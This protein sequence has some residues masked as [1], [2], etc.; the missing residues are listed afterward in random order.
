MT[1]ILTKTPELNALHQVIHCSS[2]NCPFLLF[3]ADAKAFFSKSSQW[4][5]NLIELINCIIIFL[6]HLRCSLKLW[7]WILVNYSKVFLNFS[8][9]GS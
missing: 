4:T 3:Y 2:F 7:R 5:S 8:Y 1:V 6:L 9:K